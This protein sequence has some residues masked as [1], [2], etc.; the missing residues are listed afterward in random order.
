MGK[1]SWGAP[2]GSVSGLQR[3]LQAQPHTVRRCHSGCTPICRGHGSYS[4]APV[5]ANNSGPPAGQTHGYKAAGKVTVCPGLLLMDALPQVC[6]AFLF[7][8]RTNYTSRKKTAPLGSCLLPG[9][10]QP[11]SM[12]IEA[13]I[14]GV[15][16]AKLRKITAQL[17]HSWAFT[18]KPPH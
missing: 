4:L 5:N 15:H 12:V 3:L 8:K 9:N 18:L 11:F 2:G 1:W 10:V 17:K 14:Y 6:P 16:A 7:S 13:V